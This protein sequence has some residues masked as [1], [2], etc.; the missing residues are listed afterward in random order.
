MGEFI[1]LEF[2]RKKSV[3]VK[4]HLLEIKI[5]FAPIFVWKTSIFSQKTEISK[6]IYPKLDIPIKNIYQL[7]N[8]KLFR[9]IKIILSHS[10]ESVVNSDYRGQPRLSK[11]TM[12]VEDIF[13]EKVMVV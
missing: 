13:D 9:A 4:F 5:I 7:V 12:T 6:K 8:E 2:S 1:K 11:T 3:Q 10:R